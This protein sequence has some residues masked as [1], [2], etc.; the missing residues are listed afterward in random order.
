MKAD[1]V[2]H[3]D[4][5]LE[6]A[7]QADSLRRNK[8]CL[9]SLL[10]RLRALSLQAD[11]DTSGL[12]AGQLAY[13]VHRSV[14][15]SPAPPRELADLLITVDGGP[16]VR[17][18]STLG[19]DLSHFAGIPDVDRRQL[20]E[21]LQVL[22]C[23]EALLGGVEPGPSSWQLLLADDERD[24]IVDEA[25]DRGYAL[26]QNALSA[27]VRARLEEQ[28]GDPLD[29]VDVWPDAVTVATARATIAYGSL[30]GLSGLLELG[31]T[32]W[33]EPLQ[34]WLQSEQSTPPPELLAR[35]G[36]WPVILS[37]ATGLADKDYQALAAQGPDAR[38]FSLWAMRRRCQ[39]HLRRLDWKGGASIARAL[40]AM[41]DGEQED[42]ESSAWASTALALSGLAM[43]DY[44]RA[45]GMARTAERTA[46]LSANETLQRTC[47]V[48][49][50][51]IMEGRRRAAGKRPVDLISP[52]LLLGLANESVDAA[53]ARRALRTQM[54]IHGR[55]S[56]MPLLLNVAYVRVTR[57]NAGVRDWVSLPA[58]A[59]PEPL[60]GLTWVAPRLSQPLGPTDLEKRRARAWEHV[61]Q[62]V[63]SSLSLNVAGTWTSPRDL[64]RDGMHDE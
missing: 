25:L 4:V 42:F 13:M 16:C 2:D 27:Y 6:Y 56:S 1:P 28:I 26:P 47:A 60:H 54:R 63:W 36:L 7:V 5:P 46:V 59:D 34:E 49:S 19:A 15:D 12:S 53:S 24:R 38:R 45:V 10:S 30:D 44:D 52:Y 18:L 50:Q 3:A 58:V 32:P 17:A 35:H 37:Q 33:A 31:A 20:S 14:I 61:R 11:L 21:P 55:E 48:N 57:M 40:R 23:I 51:L 22:L 29:L 64:T 43:N 8:R 41:S 62:A 39:D 9:R